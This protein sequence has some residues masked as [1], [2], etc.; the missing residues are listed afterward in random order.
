MLAH[1]KILLGWD[2]IIEGGLSKTA[3][4]MYWRGWTEESHKDWDDFSQRLPHHLK[5][6][7]ILDIKPYVPEID[8][9]KTGKIGWLEKNVNK[10]SKS[11]DDGR[12]IKE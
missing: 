9:R 11:Q 12:F 2:E 6:L 8:I 7:D 3:C 5:I 4:V 10:L 1:N